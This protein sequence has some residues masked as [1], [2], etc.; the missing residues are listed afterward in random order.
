MIRVVLAVV[1]ATALFGVSLPAAER[2][3]RDRNAELATDELSSLAR[4]ADALADGNAALEAGRV[5]AGTTVVVD[6]PDPSLTDGGRLVVG[7]DRLVWAPRTG[8]NRTVESAVPIRVETPLVLTG[9][10]R[11]RLSLISIGRAVV[12][13]IRRARVQKRSRAQNPRVRGTPVDR[14]GLSV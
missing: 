13:R 7:N 8:R 10:T 6:P 4:E 1:V 9:R 2:V 11:L 12:V 14:P 3:E 5:P